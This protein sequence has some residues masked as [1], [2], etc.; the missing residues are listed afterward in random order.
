MALLRLGVFYSL[1]RENTNAASSTP[2]H[3]FNKLYVT[4]VLQIMI[5]IC[6]LVRSSRNFF[7]FFLLPQ[8]DTLRLRHI[9]LLEATCLK[10]RAEYS[11]ISQT[12]DTSRSRDLFFV[13]HD[14][15]KREAFH[16]HWRILIIIYK[17]IQRIHI[18]ANLTIV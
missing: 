16:G 10:A 4:F 14:G 5:F 18:C 7:F 13:T 6:A 15:E 9:N 12:G 17:Y 8:V 11:P 2:H 1:V 3:Y